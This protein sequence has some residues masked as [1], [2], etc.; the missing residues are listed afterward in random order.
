MMFRPVPVSITHNNP[1]L[2]PSPRPAETSLGD[3]IVDRRAPARRRP[4]AGRHP[5]TVGHED[6]RTV[7]SRHAIRRAQLELPLH[8]GERCEAPPRPWAI[9]ADRPRRCREQPRPSGSCA[10]PRR[11]PGRIASHPRRRPAT[12][13][14]PCLRRPRRPLPRTYAKRRKASWK[15]DELYLRAHV[16]PAWGPRDAALITR[17]DA[18]RL[19]FTIAE[20]APV[21]ANRVRSILMQVFGWAVE[22]GS[23]AKRPCSA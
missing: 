2:S 18:T 11:P 8:P 22:P 14:R 16:R 23:S 4:A 13:N 20:K 9:S 17:Q 3:R 7:L 15:N 10:W 1:R 12:R 19:L 5:R 21:S 6:L